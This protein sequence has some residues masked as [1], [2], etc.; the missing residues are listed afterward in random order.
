[1]AARA[2]LGEDLAALSAEFRV[3]QSLMAL[4]VAECFGTATALIKRRV[5][6][7]RGTA[8]DW[9]TTKEGWAELVS[10]LRKRPEAVRINHLG[11]SRGRLVLSVATSG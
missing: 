8:W 6:R 4:R 1:M 9:P 10:R 5:V 7:T 2:R 3:F 11:D